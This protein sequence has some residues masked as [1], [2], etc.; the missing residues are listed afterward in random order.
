MSEATL[1]DRLGGRDGIDAVV[2]DFYDRVL[3]DE[4][5]EA[6]FEDSDPAEL[7]AHQKRFVAHV[8][9]GPVAYDGAEMAAA[10]DHLD[11]T[12]EAFGRVAD[13]LAASLEANDVPA[14]AREELLD[15]VVSLEPAVVSA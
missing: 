1:Y 12:A 3:A 6:Y 8:A 14:A 2:D 15:E 7:R 5:L 13:H 10:H 4:S 11:V 9:G